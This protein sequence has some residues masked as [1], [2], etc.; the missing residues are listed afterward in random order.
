MPLLKLKLY[1]QA[2][3][4]FTGSGY[5]F[6]SIKDHILNQLLPTFPSHHSDCIYLLNNRVPQQLKGPNHLLSLWEKGAMTEE[7][8]TDQALPWP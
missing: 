8:T 6:I 7:I 4:V 2:I 1:Y 3:A 5:F